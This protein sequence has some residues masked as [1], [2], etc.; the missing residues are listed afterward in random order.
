MLEGGNVRMLEKH[1]SKAKTILLIAIPI[2]TLLIVGWVRV[3]APQDPALVM[4]FPDSIQ[5]QQASALASPRLFHGKVASLGWIV[6]RD[7]HR[8][9]QPYLN[10]ASDNP[11]PSLAVTRV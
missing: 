11:D 8:G 6:G 3:L 10:P 4:M 9:L 5:S 7:S 1:F 2:L